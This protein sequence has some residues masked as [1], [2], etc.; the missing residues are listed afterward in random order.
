MTKQSAA[1]RMNLL[2]T[3]IAAQNDKFDRLMAMMAANAGGQAAP[4]TES[5]IADAKAGKAKHD[6]AKTQT[7]STMTTTPKLGDLP[8][9][10]KSKRDVEV[11]KD[12]SGSGETET[13]KLWLQDSVR[14][15]LAVQLTDEFPALTFRCDQLPGGNPLTFVLKTSKGGSLQYVCDSLKICVPLADNKAAVE[16]GGQAAYAPVNQ[17]HRKK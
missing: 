12:K 2:E 6:K 16:C 5:V 4:T 3:A 9:L 7:A 8:L 13:K 10:D 15:Y 11:P 17:F 1:D 14:E